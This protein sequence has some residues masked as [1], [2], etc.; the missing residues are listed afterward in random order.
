[1]TKDKNNKTKN[2]LEFVYLVFCNKE[3][4]VYGVYKS[5]NKAINYAKDLIKWRFEG[6]KNRGFEA[7]YYH[8]MDLAR[9]EDDLPKFGNFPPRK[10]Y[11]E[12]EFDKRELTVFS[13]CLNIAEDKG[14]FGDHG[15]LIKVERRPIAETYLNR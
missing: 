6:A 12:S 1:M 10:K 2:K 3:P 9:P 14:E 11:K 4:L 13:A 15:C 8:Y 7:G 5:K